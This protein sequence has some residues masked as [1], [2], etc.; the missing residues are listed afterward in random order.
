MFVKI[1]IE[2][3]F[4]YRRVREITTILNIAFQARKIDKKFGREFWD[5]TFSA[6][7]EETSHVSSDDTRY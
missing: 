2:D 4:H 7:Q 3:N 5:S 1:S 6:P